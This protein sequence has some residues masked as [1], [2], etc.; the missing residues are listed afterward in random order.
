M[1]SDVPRVMLRSPR[2]KVLT[3][4]ALSCSAT[5]FALVACGSFAEGTAE[6]AVDASPGTDAPPGIDVSVADG[7]PPDGAL[8]DIRDAAEAGEGGPCNGL[9]DCERFVFV[10]SDTYTGEDIGGAIA[11]DGK[12]TNRAALVQASAAL[13]GRTFRAWLSD[14][15]DNTQPVN[16]MTHGTR[17]YRLEDGTLI[18]N[19]WNQLVSGAGLLHAINRDERGGVIDAAAYV[20]TGT[21]AFGTKTSQTC[22]S[23]TIGGAVTDGTIG[24][25]TMTDSTWTNTGIAGCGLGHHLYCIEQ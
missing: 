7:A 3:A 2:W 13:R 15:I 14:D 20:W 17:P 16:R 10:T 4:A 9:A 24:K 11:G 21:T 5:A 22:T 8:V 1:L 19:D 18:A 6:P 25:P 23:W 12:C